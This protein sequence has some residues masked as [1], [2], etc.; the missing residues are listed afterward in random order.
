MNYIDKLNMAFV[1]RALLLARIT[2]GTLQ[3]TFHFCIPKK[4]LATL[5]RISIPLIPFHPS[6][7]MD[8]C[9]GKRGR[10]RGWGTGDTLGPNFPMKF[11]PSQNKTLLSGGLHLSIWT[12][13]PR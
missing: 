10:G 7:C 3:I 5:T 6:I 2:V 13:C 1:L 9:E 8:E 4:D 12:V 11:T